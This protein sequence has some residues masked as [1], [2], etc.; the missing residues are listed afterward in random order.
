A[1]EMIADPKIEDRKRYV[2]DLANYM[3]SQRIGVEVCVTSNLQTIP[4][5]KSIASHPI[6][7]MIDYGLSV[8]VCTDNRLVSNT[9]VSREVGLIVEGAKVTRPELKRLIVA[10]FKGAF[11]HGSFA[12]KRRFVEAVERRYD[13]VA[14]APAAK[15]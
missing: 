10:G 13:A 14:A 7:R 3:A 4:S 9:T 12:E 11:F 5:L 2:E 8:S 15:R 1:Q 6:R